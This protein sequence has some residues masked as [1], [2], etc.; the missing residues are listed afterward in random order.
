[1]SSSSSLKSI[2]RL[3]TALA[4]VFAFFLCNSEH[5]RFFGALES[6]DIYRGLFKD[7]YIRDHRRHV[8]EHLDIST[9]TCEQGLLE[10]YLRVFKGLFKVYS[11]VIQGLF[12]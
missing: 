11:R 10:G 9:T 3:I 1:M 6:L 8:M 7:Y 4:F 2:K 5:L 12:Y